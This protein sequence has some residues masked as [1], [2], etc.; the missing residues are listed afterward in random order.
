M[1]LGNKLQFIIH[2]PIAVSE[3]SFEELLQQ[4]EKAIVNSIKN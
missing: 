4:T 2:E 1:G 3:Y